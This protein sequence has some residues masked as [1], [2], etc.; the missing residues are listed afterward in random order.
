[1]TWIVLPVE[2]KGIWYSP[3]YGG[4]SVYLRDRFSPDYPPDRLNE[5]LKKAGR[6]ELVRKD[7]KYAN[8]KWMSKEELEEKY[9]KIEVILVNKEK[10]ESDDHY[11]PNENNLLIF[12]DKYVVTM[13][14]YDGLEYFIALP[15]DYKKLIDVEKYLGGMDNEKE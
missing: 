1:M 9:G 8:P 2:F 13:G 14:E 11:P 4:F 3:S 5:E 7:H 6:W 15:R 12:T 10:W